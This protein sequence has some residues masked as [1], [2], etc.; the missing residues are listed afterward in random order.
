MTFDRKDLSSAGA[1]ETGIVALAPAVANTLFAATGTRVLSLPMAPR[2][3]PPGQ[4]TTP[5][6]S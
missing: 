5:Y 4:L 2:T 3:V 1:G 6:R